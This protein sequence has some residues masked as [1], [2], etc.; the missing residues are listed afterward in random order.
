[1]EIFKESFVRNHVA[2][3]IIVLMFVCLLSLAFV[4]QTTLAFTIN[5]YSPYYSGNKNSN[6]VSLMFNVYMGNEYIDGI[7]EKLKNADAKATFFVGGCWVAKNAEVLQK[8]YNAGHEIGNHG[9]WHKEHKNLSAE[10]NKKEMELT[11]KIVKTTIGV[12]M[13]LFAPPSGSFGQNT[14]D[15]AQNLGYKTI[16]WTKDTI[17]WRDKNSDIIYTRATKNPCG[18][19]L[20]LMHPT[21]HTLH[22][23]E[24]VLMFYNSRG[25]KLTTV[26][27]NIL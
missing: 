19:D 11:H 21:K 3:F 6:N 5:N 25:Y 20:I 4:G 2:N 14:L 16:M 17:D 15:I 24:D 22:A 12:E 13:T 27:Q 1:M 7:L 26:S 8:I 18:G 23:L 10:E 9:Y